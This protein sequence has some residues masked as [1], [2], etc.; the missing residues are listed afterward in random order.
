[1]PIKGYRSQARLITARHR[2]FLGGTRTLMVDPVSSALSFVDQLSGNSPVRTHMAFSHSTKADHR[3]GMTSMTQ[4]HNN[5]TTVTARANVRMT[6]CS[7]SATG[8]SYLME[9][10]NTSPRCFTS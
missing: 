9:S 5:P 4:S 8:F 2:R 7:A 1:M 3:R 6:K 10:G